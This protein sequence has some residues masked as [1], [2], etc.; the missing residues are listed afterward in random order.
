MRQQIAHRMHPAALPG[1]AQHLGDRRLQADM[2]VRDHQLD[3]A[4]TAPHQAAQELG[5]EGFRF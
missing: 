2:R 3:A 4:Q 5:P 1:G